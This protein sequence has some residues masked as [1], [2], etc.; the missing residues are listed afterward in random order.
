[1]L[2]DAEVS[3]K[4]QAVVQRDIKAL[5]PNGRL[6]GDFWTT[7][8]VSVNLKSFAWR[9]SFS[10]ANGDD[11]NS[12]RLHIN[13]EQ[14]K[15]TSNENI[16][17]ADNAPEL[18]KTRNIPNK[19][20]HGNITSWNR[21][22]I[23]HHWPYHTVDGKISHYV[24]RY[25]NA[26]GGKETP[27]MTLRSVN[28]LVKWVFC[29]LKGKTILYNL[30]LLEKHPHA[31][32]LISEGEKCADAAYKLFS[33]KNVLDG[34]ITVSWQGGCNSVDKADWEPLKNRQVILWPD[35][36]L[37]TDKKTEVLL[38]LEK[39]P[40]YAAM[41][42]IAAI[43]GNP[44]KIKIITPD[45]TKPDGWDI[46][47]A[48]L[49]DKWA[50]QEVVD[51]IKTNLTNLPEKMPV[52]E[53]K[54]Q[55]RVIQTANTIT[56]SEELEPLFSRG[57]DGRISGIKLDPVSIKIVYDE[58]FK[59]CESSYWQYEDNSGL[60]KSIEKYVVIKLAYKKISTW[61]QF[62][63]SFERE[64]LEKKINDSNSLLTALEYPH[65]VDVASDNDCFR[66][67]P[68]KKIVHCLDTML[69]YKNGNW[70]KEPFSPYFYSRNQIP[71]KYDPKAKC[72]RF[73]NEVIMRNLDP[74]DA[75]LLQR[76]AGQ[77]LLGTNYFQKILI[78]RGLAGSGKS[79]IMNI[80]RSVIGESNC[81]ELRTSK[82]TGNFEIA[83][84]AR[85]LLL[86]GS[87]VPADFLNNEG[88]RELKK[89]VGGD[90]L[91]CEKKGSSLNWSIEGR[92]N[93]V[94]TT[95]SKLLV[96]LEGDE[97]AWLRRLAIIDFDKHPT[98][99]PIPNFAQLLLK[100]EG[101]GILNWILWG[102]TKLI[103]DMET[104]KDF[105]MSQEQKDRVESLLFESDSVRMFVK[106]KIIVSENAKGATTEE[107]TNAYFGYCEEKAWGAL[108]LQLFEKRLPN[109]ML[110]MFRINK[111][112]HIKRENRDGNETNKNGYPGV[113]IRLNE[114]K[115]TVVTDEF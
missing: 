27:P 24:V 84:I 107:M 56:T 113:T 96:K 75:D 57:A 76:Y 4:I 97:G 37:K 5:L 16:P 66:R 18:P 110:E 26:D 64:K 53:Q 69:V 70:E 10:D 85:S 59:F 90:L 34:M 77:I 43:L 45:Q 6:N 25:N 73:L 111:S 78:L 28:G 72:D 94:I 42:K 23:T 48:I 15:A 52:K 80:F 101:S 54:K 2:T 81:S 83:I 49:N 105:I 87:D 13:P 62:F 65:I 46:A 31:S 40:G 63:N 58:K 103:N 39:Q 21:Y 36:D 44:K 32:V 19:D 29:G 91:S 20:D 55:T 100:D 30:H 38:P 88:S 11:Y 35:N 50:Y 112:S 71:I 17:I 1:M 99:K 95:N 8:S 67:D 114:S 89:L 104:G 51:F 33:E 68:E 92:F 93:I 3:K 106:N 98:C 109:I 74:D 86:C 115:N 108:P 47:D 9:D 12:L 102:A 61:L 60:W 79:T 14:T 7:D 22:D 82:L 41:L